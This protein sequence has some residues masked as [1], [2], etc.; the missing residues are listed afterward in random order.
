MIPE[1]ENASVE[2]AQAAPTQSLFANRPV[3][4]GLSSVQG[5]TVGSEDQREVPVVEEP[6][7]EPA[8]I[9]QDPQA[10][11]PE[12]MDTPEAEAEPTP[13]PLPA[14][15]S[16]PVEP[17]DAGEPA[18]TVEPEAEQEA[19]DA[20]AE[21][22][23]QPVSEPVE[24]DDAEVT[25]EEVQA[26]HAAE[27]AAIEKAE[28]VEPLTA[29]HP[30]HPDVTVAP[31]KPKSV[32]EL[33]EEKQKLEAELTARQSEERKAVIAQIAAVVKTYNIPVAEL[34]AALG[35]VPNPR[36]GTKAP[37][38]YRDGAN[39]WSGRGKLPNW[40]KGKNPED[41]RVG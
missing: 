21:S 5:D 2:A 16:E 22:E 20:L 10:E 37:I 7:S 28:E 3:D 23:E 8:A 39:E 14:G 13:E 6:H 11:L 31:A 4:V 18:E 12:I 19:E 40:L 1:N 15:V 41:Y 29:D 36:K 26:R 27:D 33:Q 24:A 32:K 17:E 25:L 34:A 38:L 30:D 35:G 9:P